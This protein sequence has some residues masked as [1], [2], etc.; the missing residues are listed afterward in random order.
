MA[1]EL[2]F[3][4]AALR[5]HL[6]QSAV[7]QQIAA[8]EAELGARMF[9]R[10]RRRVTLTA[11]GAALLDRVDTVLAG[12]A[13]ARRAVAASRGAIEG[14]LRVSASRTVGTF[15][16]PRPLATL[17]RRHAALRL[18]IAI[19]NTEQVLA[20]V[21]AGTVDVGYV[22]DEVAHPAVAVETLRDDEL[23]VV[24]AA[25][26][27]FASMAEIP[28]EELAI[29]PLI[30]REPGSGTRRIAEQHLLA[31]GVRPDAMRVVAELAGIEPI[32]T[33][34]EAGLG[35]SIISRAALTKELALG[36]LVARPL[37]G[38]T[39]RRRI[40]AVTLDGASDL[41][42]ARELTRLL[43]ALPGAAPDH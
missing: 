9:D 26:H 42:A 27:R 14:D 37:A 31:L 8:L 10:S 1:R 21:L 29:E 25:A 40:S 41:P 33:A 7:S 32:K 30:V 13:E 36:S 28:P 6:S 39:M 11:A 16:L 12:F 2:S 15:L 18:H 4:Q 35:V 5:L 38:T 24:A 22:E 19:E 34:V 23:L 20:A 43:A 17:G 3:T